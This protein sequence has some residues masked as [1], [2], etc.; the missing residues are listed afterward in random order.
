MNNRFNGVVM[1]G[2]AAVV[3]AGCGSDEKSANSHCSVAAQS[4]CDGGQVCENVADGSTGCFAPLVVRGRV[5]DAADPTHAVSGSMVAA[6]DI[7]GELVSRGLAKTGSDGSYE[8]VIPATRTADGAPSVE[9]LTL[10][11]DAA[12]FASFPSGLRVALPVDGQH[13]VQQGGKWL[14]EN[15]STEIGLDRLA[16]TAGLGT[17]QGFVR[18][19]AP[20]GTLV[21]AGAASALSSTDG[22]FTLFNVPSGELEIRGYKAGLQLTPVATTVRAGVTVDGIELTRSD[23]PLGAVSGSV[24][25][26]NAG[27]QQTSVVLV[28]K[29]TFNESLARGEVPVGL[30]QFPVS[31]QYR[32]KQV[33]AGEYVVLAAFE[34]DQLV[35]DPDVSI[36]GTTTQEITVGGDTVAVPGFKITGA[37]AVVAPGAM[38]P[39]PL[40]GTPV[41]SWADD[42]SEDGYELTVFDTFGKQVYRDADVPRVTGSGDVSLAYAGPALAPG[43]YQF[44]A[45]SYR[46]DKA[47]RTYISATEDLKGVFIVQ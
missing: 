5:V 43:Y 2:F 30:R 23:Q 3:A 7:N 46:M 1:V 33:P 4:G 17:I 36:G 41:F 47:A 34:N 39:E 35:R 42:S 37:L 18:A 14:I 12:G 9:A 19:D 28:V 16:S 22:S 24:S 15:G 26:V 32:F 6:R 13:P 25:F 45:V 44:R 40:S 38:G 21:V 11:A 31:G 29:S 8:L 10:R 27:T 20:G